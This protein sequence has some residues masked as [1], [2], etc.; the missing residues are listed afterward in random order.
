MPR[1]LHRNWRWEG[2]LEARTRLQ[3][4]WHLGCCYS[5]PAFSE[6]K[7][8]GGKRGRSL[9]CHQH[10]IWSLP[11]PLNWRGKKLKCH[12]PCS[13]ASFA[14]VGCLWQWE[15]QAPDMMG[16]WYISGTIGTNSP[17]VR[18]FSVW[19]LGQFF[20][21]QG[22]RS[23]FPTVPASGGGV[24]VTGFIRRW[25]KSEGT[26]LPDAACDIPMDEHFL[27]LS[28]CLI[29]TLG[30][31]LCELCRR[32]EKLSTE[33]S[34]GSGHT[35]STLDQGKHLQRISFFVNSARPAIFQ[36]LLK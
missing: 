26:S 25:V 27:W 1:C 35:L 29:Q 16:M 3:Q 17:W 8:G 2:E 6:L 13:G 19:K 33:G 4:H 31:K 11:S 7:Q 24:L 34:G 30:R 10:S 22:C 5:L 32:R 14:K 18:L 15:A 9:C 36:S 12:C 21:I 28:L 20:F 23:A